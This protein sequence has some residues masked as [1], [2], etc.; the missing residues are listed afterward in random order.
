MNG[1]HDMGGMDGFGVVDATETEPNF[2]TNWE[3]RVLALTLAMGATGTWNLDQSRFAR[4]CLAPADYLSIG[5]YRIWL[6]ALEHLLLRYELVTEQEIDCGNLLEAPKELGR[7]LKAAD[8]DTTLR[9]GS[10]VDRQPNTVATFAVGSIIKV[11]NLHTQGHTRLPGYIRGK[12][13]RIARIHGVHVF[14]DSNVTG[15]GEDPH[16]LY[17]V[18]FSGEELWGRSDAATMD[19]MVDCWEPYLLPLS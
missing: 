12:V 10:P 4:E 2:H 18:A 11:K 8:V 3:G 17:S 1:V 19:V 6:S 14:P 7:R 5:Y 15:L 9:A 13:G 16:W